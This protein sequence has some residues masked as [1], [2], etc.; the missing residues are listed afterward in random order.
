MEGVI[1][2]LREACEGEDLDKV[3][4]LMETLNNTWQQISTKLYEQTNAE[5]P[6]NEDT[7]EE[8]TDVEFEEVKE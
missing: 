2:E 7:S 5:Q 8:V 4:T 3:N 1:K 6:T